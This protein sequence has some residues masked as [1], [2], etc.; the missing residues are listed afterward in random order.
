M[1]GISKCRTLFTEYTGLTKRRLAKLIACYL[2]IFLDL[3][4]RQLHTK[5][6]KVNFNV[7]ITSVM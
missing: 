1:W 6:I 7:P 5:S 2:H 3:H 4:R